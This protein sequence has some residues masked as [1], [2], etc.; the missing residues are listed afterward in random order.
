M[1][2]TIAN[3]STSSTSSTMT[4]TMTTDKAAKR[5]QMSYRGLWS[6]L[7]IALI[8]LPLLLWNL[9]SHPVPWFDEGFT[10]HAA[11]TLAERGVY[12]T[13]N[14]QDGYLHFDSGVS[15]GPTLVIPIALS[16]KLLGYGMWQARLVSVLFTMALLWGVFALMKRLY[17]QN[18]GL[19][20][21]M[22]L[23]GWPNFA[24]AGFLNVSRQVLGEAPALAFLA[25]GW[26]V[27]FKSWSARSTRLA[28]LAGLLFGLG[29]VTKSQVAIVFLP[30]LGLISLLRL[31]KDRNQLVRWAMPV[32]M[33]LAASA[34]WRG[35]E[36]VGQLG[37]SPALQ[38]ANADGYVK[39]IELL[40][41]PFNFGSLLRR[42]DWLMVV[43][44]WVGGVS[45]LWR[46][47]VWQLLKPNQLDQPYEEA[48]LGLFAVLY[49]IWYG[50]ISIGWSRYAFVGYVIGILLCT[51]LAH[52]GMCWL[53]A[54]LPEPLNVGR[55]AVLTH[56]LGAMLAMGLLIA[57]SVDLLTMRVDDSA[58]LTANF[59]RNQVP[60]N[61]IIETWE[62]EL[63]ALS[64]HW[65]IH[66]PSEADDFEAIHQIFYERKAPQLN[67]DELQAN[68]DYLIVGTMSD[69]TGVYDE[70]TLNKHFRPLI[71][72]GSYRVYQRVR[73]N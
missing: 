64:D 46:A 5:S 35:V 27:L 32:M 71:E 54:R 18:V 61:A 7:L 57:A 65:E 44:M 29:L 30:A 26:W 11:R 51:K 17:G 20:S 59:I 34:I 58:Q 13:Y 53:F 41:L 6:Y 42:A 49:A 24:G 73:S 37:A 45:C 55:P 40:L 39:S 21:V 72:F 56:K 8:A 43:A 60:R 47:R 25:V 48:A 69:Y 33:T 31:P 16:F 23:L 52:D 19:L 62:W 67:Y 68:P 70:A 66:H 63:D 10:T 22:I 12:G 2:R 28:A 1:Q 4:T 9:D 14:A 50:F 38:Q 36:Y 15:T 3:T